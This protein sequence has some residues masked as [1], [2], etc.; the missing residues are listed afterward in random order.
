VSN[1]A[2]R[3]RDGSLVVVAHNQGHQ[4]QSVEVAVGDRHVT[5]TLARGPR[6]PTGSGRRTGWLGP[7][8]WAGW[9]WTTA[10]ARPAPRAVG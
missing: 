7:V 4:A 6:R 1:V 10:A 9:T 8:T 3:N 5:T 2:Y